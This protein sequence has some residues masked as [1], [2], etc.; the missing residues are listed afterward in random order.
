MFIFISC[1]VLFSKKENISDPNYVEIPFVLRNKR[2]TVEAIV[3]GKRGRFVFDT[4]STESYASVKTMNLSR[5]GHT[6]TLYKGK[7]TTVEIYNLP[8][9]VFNNVELRTRS[10][11]INR[12]DFIA[13]SQNDGFDGILGAGVFEGYWCELSF[14]KSKIILYKEK[15]DYY[16]NFSPVKILDKYNADFF[17]PCVIDGETFYFDI[18]TGAPA[19]LYFPDG[20]IKFKKMDDY[21]EIMSS[22]PGAEIYHLVKTDL[23][24]LLDETYTEY[25]VMTN[26][27]YSARNDDTYNDF[28]ILGIDFLKYYDFLFDYRDLREGKSTGLYYKA[29]TPVEERNYGVYSFIKAVPEFGILNTTGFNKSGF[30]VHRILKDS[31]AYEMFGFRPNMTI[32]RI[33][34]KP[35]AEI[36]QEELFES[37][38]YLTF[39]NYTILEEDTERTILSPLKSNLH[40]ILPANR[41]K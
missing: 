36:P 4:G 20:L 2:I 10:W 30:V 39:D 41:S 26:S 29:N 1:S 31:I 9:I 37:S 5:Y 22:D 11:I 32:T 25:F 7:N 13:K 21:R 15:P 14:S 8:K 23:I 12:S 6:I 34:G 19:G 27:P 35:I 38:S 3:N 16:T 28:G 24:H 17:I 33:N 18:D 40:E